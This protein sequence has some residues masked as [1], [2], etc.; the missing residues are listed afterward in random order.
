[1]ADAAFAAWLSSPGGSAAALALAFVLG[2]MVG[3]FLNV[4][5]HRVPRGETVVCDRSRCPACG[6]TIRAWDNLP[7]VGWLALRGR[8]RDCGA[9]ISVHYPLVEAACGCLAAAVAAGELP[10]GADASPLGAMAAWAGRTAVVMTLVSWTL[11]AARGHTVSRWTAGTVVAATGIVAACVEGL[12]P[13]PIGYPG[14]AWHG[15]APWVPSALAAVAGTAAGRAVGS[16]LDGS[17]RAACTVVGAAL[18]WQAAMLVA[19]L[20]WS[21]RPAGRR[22]VFGC[23]VSAVATVAGRPLAAAWEAVWRTFTGG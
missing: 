18:G 22:A 14:T 4:V 16:G 5:V 15:W 2:S 8:C 1:M 3:S 19:T 23:A 11:L 7:I 9:W 21:T 20:T 13:L 12:Q 17:A 10:S 6:S